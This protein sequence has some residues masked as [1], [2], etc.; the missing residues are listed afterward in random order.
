VGD[1]WFQQQRD[2][3]NFTAMNRKFEA[4][5]AERTRKSDEFWKNWNKDFSA[6]GAI[7]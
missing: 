7:Q 1:T 4:E 5:N 3:A 2:R 6:A